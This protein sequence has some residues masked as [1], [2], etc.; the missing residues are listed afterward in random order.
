M[1]KPTKSKGKKA[2]KGPMPKMPSPGRAMKGDAHAAEAM[3]KADTVPVMAGGRRK[4]VM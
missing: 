3:M 2:M 1:K 4:G